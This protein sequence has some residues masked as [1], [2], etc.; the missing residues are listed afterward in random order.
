MFYFV[1]VFVVTPPCS[2]LEVHNILISTT[3]IGSFK[4]I[5]VVTCTVE[6]KYIL[7]NNYYIHLF[8]GI[9]LMNGAVENIQLLQALANT[10]AELNVSSP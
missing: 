6:L 7:G 8:N 2:G 9:D 10:H 4:L 3:G 1:C 5:S